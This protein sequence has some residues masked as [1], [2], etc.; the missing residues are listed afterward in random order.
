[1]Q[2]YFETA[3]KPTIAE[4]DY[5]EANLVV[6]EAKGISYTY[7]QD[8]ETIIKTTKDKNG[9]L[10]EVEMGCG[11]I[12]VKAA[13]KKATKTKEAFISITAELTPD[14]QKDYEIIPYSPYET[15]NLQV[16]A[17]FMAKHIIKP[18]EYGDNIIGVEINF[19]KEFYQPEQLRSVEDITTDLSDLEKDLV[20]LEKELEL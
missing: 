5:K 7:N 8:K 13:Y 14:Y 11:K 10:S 20:N 19:N 16:I 1:L 9:T 2:H 12:V 18:F 3:I 17:D 15:E 4:L 6:T